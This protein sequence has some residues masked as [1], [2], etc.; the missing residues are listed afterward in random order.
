MILRTPMAPS[1]HGPTDPPIDKPLA[2]AQAASP[3]A[4]SPS[5]SP[6]TRGRERVAPASTARLAR[7]L[8]ILHS[9]LMSRQAH[10]NTS[11]A[12]WSVPS[13]KESKCMIRS[14]PATPVSEEGSKEEVP[15]GLDDG[16]LYSDSSK[17]RFFINKRT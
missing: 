9:R 4:T 1:G 15:S 2:A 5:R 6:R 3:E 12:S 7:S 13:S 8:L 10:L 14:E 11:S 16:R 17:N